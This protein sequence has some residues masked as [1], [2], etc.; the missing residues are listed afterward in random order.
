[1]LARWLARFHPA[2]HQLRKMMMIKKK[3]RER[4]R[5]SERDPDNHSPQNKSTPSVVETNEQ[6]S[7]GQ[8]LQR[9]STIPP[10][11]PQTLYFVLCACL[12]SGRKLRRRPRPQG[13]SRA[14]ARGGGERRAAGCSQPASQPGRRGGGASSY[15]GGRT[16]EQTDRQGRQAFRG[17]GFEEHLLPP[18]RTARADPH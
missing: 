7:F 5:A 18:S 11:T 12:L 17:A 8:R 3:R 4:E 6:S 16:D 15:G 10:S 9:V 1:M 2:A 14:P 13:R